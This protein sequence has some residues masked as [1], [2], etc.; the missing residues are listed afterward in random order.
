MIIPVFESIGDVFNDK[1][2]KAQLSGELAGKKK[3]NDKTLQNSKAGSRLRRDA[4]ITL[5]ELGF[6]NWDK[7]TVEFLKIENK[8]SKFSVRE[9][10]Y[11]HGLVEHC[12]VETLQYYEELKK[13]SIKEVETRVPEVVMP[14]KPRK[15]RAKKVK[16]E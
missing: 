14:K 11:I 2:F 10:D 7:L 5:S 1:K 12:I 8:E 6:L 9:R 16:E 4:Y 13:K 15:P 3:A